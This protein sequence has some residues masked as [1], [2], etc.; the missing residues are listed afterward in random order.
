MNSGSSSSMKGL[1]NIIYFITST[2][3]IKRVLAYKRT[4][5]SSSSSSLASLSKSLEN[6]S[7]D[8]RNIR[9]LPID[10]EKRIFNRQVSNS[11]FSLV[12]PTPVINPTTLATSIDAFELLGIK[13]VIDDEVSKYLSGNNIM[14]GSTPAAHCYCG[15]QFGT[16][17]G[18]LGDGA[19]M[20]LG[21]II[22][23]ETGMR[24]E[25]QLKGAGPTPYSR[26]AD[27]RKVLRS[28]VREFLCSEGMHF[29]NIPT[30]R[31]ASCVT[32][33]TTVERDPLY[34][35]NAIDEK[36][37]IISRIAPNFFR[38]G[39]FEI[40]KSREASDRVGPSA[41]NLSLKKQLLDYVL[42]YYPEIL[43]KYE[44]NEQTNDSSMYKEFFNEIMHRTAQLVAKWQSVGF[45]HGVLNTDNMSIM[46]LTIDYGP[47]GFMEGFDK[48]FVPNGS[49]NGGRYSYQKQPEV[50][51]W[52]LLKLAEMLDP[53]IPLVESVS[54]LGQYDS[55][56][57]AFY[58]KE[59]RGKLGLLTELESDKELIEDLFTTIDST[60]TDFTDTFQAL[61]DYI[62]SLKTSQD[63]KSLIDKLVSRSQSPTEKIAALR[64]KMKIHRLQMH[65]EQIQQLWMLLQ[66]NAAEVSE[67]FSGA[68]VEEIR[69]E[70]LVEKNKLDKLMN[71]AMEIK[72]LESVTVESKEKAD[73]ELLNSWVK[74]YAERIVQDD[75]STG[76]R[77]D[78][79]V[80]I[81]S[82]KN[83]TF[84]L[85]NWIAQDAIKLAESGDY[86]KV[87]SV[88]SLLKTPF[89]RK[90]NTF[91][92]NFGCDDRY[93]RKTPS[94]ASSLICT[95]S[96]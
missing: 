61:T 84:I 37:T 47:Y 54:I 9:S 46:G 30:T 26:A 13:N 56:Y 41:G 33:D 66:S 48:D 91:L 51:K 1:V 64:R 35:G 12:Q 73:R 59:M 68:P 23:E 65:P 58:I 71:A 31:S 7:F 83:P 96:S 70:I 60:S 82:S 8:N 52:N 94:S 72:R 50:C 79:R 55:I 53:L 14:H 42:L 69:A 24:W 16:F 67:M 63:M 29:L 17:V 36:C 34:D 76:D 39:S 6:I 45:V 3:T 88:L 81:M 92:T 89:D 21:E 32:S 5:M 38:F 49:D 44:T 85:R 74:K 78:T 28:S 10:P 11:I 25:L 77:T 18:Q 75:E 43:K 19:T 93:F 15:H 87:K 90:F 86:S 20:Y 57:E 22:N 62:S 4:I 95:C 27:G 80:N 40:F 2:L